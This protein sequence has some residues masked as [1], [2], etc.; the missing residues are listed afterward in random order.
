[1]Y[2]KLLWVMLALGPAMLAIAR[3]EDTAEAPAAD[4]AQ[5]ARLSA[6]PS[7]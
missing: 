2:S 3:R 1:M 5:P 6:A 7:Y 4:P